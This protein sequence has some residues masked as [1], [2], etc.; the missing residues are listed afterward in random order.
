M[1]KSRH[2]LQ[3]RPKLLR[4]QVINNRMFTLRERMMVS[5]SYASK[6]GGIYFVTYFSAYT[7]PMYGVE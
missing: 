4:M 6:I 3:S 7:S 1:H 2:I 5:L